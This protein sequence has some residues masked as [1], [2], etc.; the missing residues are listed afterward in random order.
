MDNDTI[1]I[2]SIQFSLMS[3]LRTQEPHVYLSSLSENPKYT[4][5]YRF[6]INL[7]TIQLTLVHHYLF[8]YSILVQLF[9]MPCFHPNSCPHIT[10]A[11]ALKIN[12]DCPHINPTPLVFMHMYHSPATDAEYQEF[13][14]LFAA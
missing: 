11:P 10:S 14:G 1:T 2:H 4:P 3:K 12:I 7:P 9:S 5:L 6:A 13:T 8:L